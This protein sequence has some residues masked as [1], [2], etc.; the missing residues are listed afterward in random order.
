M[1]VDLEVGTGNDPVDLVG[2]HMEMVGKEVQ[3][4]NLVRD[5][6]TNQEDRRMALEG[7]RQDLEDHHD[8]N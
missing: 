8:P 5:Q 1:V 3:V 4:G 6:D 7:S 2:S